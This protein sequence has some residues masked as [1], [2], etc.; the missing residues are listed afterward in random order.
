MGFVLYGSENLREQVTD[1]RE[2]QY[3]GSE[4]ALTFAPGDKVEFRNYLVDRTDEA[5]GGTFEFYLSNGGRVYLSSLNTA[6]K[7]EEERRK[8][9]LENMIY[10]LNDFLKE[11]RIS[12]ISLRISMDFGKF[13]MSPTLWSHIFAMGYR[14]DPNPFA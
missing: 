1:N 9:I 8:H 3:S 10:E 12:S 4:G 6:F 11:L 14:I 13:S 7:D 5:Y 2:M